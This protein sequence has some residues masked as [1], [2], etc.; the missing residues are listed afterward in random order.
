MPWLSYQPTRSC[1]SA[2]ADSEKRIGVSGTRLPESEALLHLCQGPLPAGFQIRKPGHHGSHEIPLI[3]C[4]L[5][6]GHGLNDRYATATAGQQHRPVRFRHMPDHP[7]R[8]H[9]Q[10]GEGDDIFRERNYSA[11][12]KHG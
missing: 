4:C 8:I 3:L 7:P 12:L 10:I 6:V 2:R 1:R 9:L 11:V 5:E